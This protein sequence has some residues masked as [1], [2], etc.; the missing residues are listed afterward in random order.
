MTDERS[1]DLTQALLLELRAQLEEARRERDAMCRELSL[2]RD[3]ASRL[4]RERDQTRARL[5]NIAQWLRGVS[6]G[7]HDVPMDAEEYLPLVR[8]ALADARLSAEQGAKVA[9]AL[10]AEKSA[11][12]SRVAVLSAALRGLLRE[13]PNIYEGRLEASLYVSV[14]A[15]EA[16]LRAL[17]VEP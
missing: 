3:S 14:D 10:A 9:E 13:E 12:A 6:P 17:E 15:L 2:A 4:E 11:L 8:D 1:P 7:P 16:A 5:T